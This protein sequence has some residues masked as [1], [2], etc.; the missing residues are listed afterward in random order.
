MREVTKLLRRDTT[1]SNDT[2]PSYAQSIKLISTPSTTHPVKNEK[3]DLYPEKKTLSNFIY[4]GSSTTTKP[5]FVALP[6]LT[7]HSTFHECSRGSPCQPQGS[8]HRHVTKLVVIILYS[9]HLERKII[10]LSTFIIR[11]NTTTNPHR[12]DRFTPSQRIQR[13]SKLVSTLPTSFPN[14]RKSYLHRSSCLH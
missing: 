14:P 6:H 12:K 3:S 7:S 5:I 8:L 10:S 11:W 1:S 2:L 9:I 13:P 4:E